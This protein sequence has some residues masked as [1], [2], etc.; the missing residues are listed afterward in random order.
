M[1]PSCPAMYMHEPFPVVLVILLAAFA[2]L[3]SLIMMA[4][5]TF[6]FCRIFHKAGYCWALGLLTLVPLANLIMPFVLAFGDWPVQRELRR[7][8]EQPRTGTG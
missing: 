3:V 5:L 1:E 8:R 4:L 6:A 2:I 7:L